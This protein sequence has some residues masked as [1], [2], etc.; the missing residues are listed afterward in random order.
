[1]VINSINVI[2]Y[3]NIN[4]GFLNMTRNPPFIYDKE[5]LSSGLHP[6]LILEECTTRYDLDLGPRVTPV[7]TQV[8]S[9]ICH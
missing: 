7:V 8:F 9:R 4:I 1:M 2:N 5:F 3:A 6:R